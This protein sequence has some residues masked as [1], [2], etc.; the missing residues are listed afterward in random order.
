MKIATRRH[1]PQVRILQAIVVSIVTLLAISISMAA[2]CPTPQEGD[3]VLRDF[4]FK[5]GEVLP[6]LRLHYRTI[7]A[8]VQDQAGSVRNA[9]LLLHGTTGSGRFFLSPQ[10]CDTLFGPGQSLDAA[11]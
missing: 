9:V 5:S 2:S 8:P 6:E 11:R 7:G 3:L 10:F 1:S 4:Q